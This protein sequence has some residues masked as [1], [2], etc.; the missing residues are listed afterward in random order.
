[1]NTD[2][3]DQ[4]Q[5]ADDQELAGN[6]NG[7]NRNTGSTSGSNASLP[8]SDRMISRGS[9]AEEQQAAGSP[10]VANVGPINTVKIP[11]PE[12]DWSY[13]VIERLDPNTLKSSLVPFNLE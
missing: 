12:I 3:Q 1:Q 11:A 7:Q 9:L 5:D 2:N 13:A 6:A 10:S 8:S 4:D